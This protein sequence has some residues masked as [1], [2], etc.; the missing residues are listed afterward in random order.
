[1]T[2]IDFRRLLV[3]NIFRI[4]KKL[5]ALQTRADLLA[6]F[7]IEL[8]YVSSNHG[9]D[10]LFGIHGL[11]RITSNYDHVVPP[12]HRICSYT[13]GLTKYFPS[14]SCI[15]SEK[16]SLPIDRNSFLPHAH[17]RYRSTR[18]WPSGVAGSSSLNPYQDP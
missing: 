4:H 10:R 14:A 1:M 7:H 15:T 13:I 17:F 9:T 11:A 18:M 3:F 6:E 8:R 12:L 16:V 2:G 5:N